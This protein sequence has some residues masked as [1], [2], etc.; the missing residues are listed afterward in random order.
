MLGA[1]SK[2]QISGFDETVP[3]YGFYMLHY[4]NN[5]DETIVEANKAK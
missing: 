3:N 2:C 1:F 4:Q 5:A